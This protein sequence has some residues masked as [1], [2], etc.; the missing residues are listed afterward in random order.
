MAYADREGVAALPPRP[1]AAGVALMA[2]FAL[3]WLVARMSGVREGEHLALVG[4]LQSLALAVLGWRACR[5]LAFPLLYL[6][7]MVPTGEVLIPPLQELTARM[8]AA[9]LALSGIPTFREGLTIEV[10]TGRYIV[11]P[12]CAGLN[13]V[14]AGLAVSMAF[15]QFTYRRWRPRLLFV[16]AVLAVA[17]AGNW[18]RVFLVIAV[19]HLT[20]GQADIV[21]DHLFYGWGGFSALLLGVM[22]LGDRFREDGPAAIPAVRVAVQ[23]PPARRL[24]AVAGLALAAAA[25][26]SVAAVALWPTQPVRVEPAVVAPSCGIHDPIPVSPGWRV[27]ADRL[28]GLGTTGC[29]MGQSAFDLTLAVLARPVRDGKLLGLENRLLDRE[30]WEVS[31]ARIMTLAVDGRPVPVRVALVRSGERSRLVAWLAWA[32]GGWRA[33]GLSSAASDLGAE[34]RTG[35]RRAAMVMVAADAGEGVDQT[36]EAIR[37]FLARVA[38]EP[39]LRRAWSELGRETN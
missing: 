26:P 22:W 11:A 19:A 2:G 4:M 5:R 39:Q 25:L 29:R 33:P 38:V 12:G 7:L 8:S 31:G 28:D 27:E 30:H 14:L 21:D 9:M 1:A 15:A 24:V 34:L 36:F 10:P 3:A 32:D 20:D 6:W 16:L 37:T 13:F 17:V 18:L 23:P 35:Q